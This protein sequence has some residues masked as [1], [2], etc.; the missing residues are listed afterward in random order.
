MTCLVIR[1]VRTRVTGICLAD[2][3]EPQGVFLHA[4]CDTGRV[5]APCLDL[6]ARTVDS[7]TPA[8][9]I[10][11]AQASPNANGRDIVGAGCVAWLL[12]RLRRRKGKPDRKTGAQSYRS[13]G[14]E[15]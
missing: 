11:A 15:L 5:G 12:H 13:K 7:S 9:F 2:L 10:P 14:R 6:R 4:F 3:P 8:V 1:S